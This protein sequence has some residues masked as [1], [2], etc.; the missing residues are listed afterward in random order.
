MRTVHIGKLVEGEFR[1]LQKE[2]PEYTVKWLAE[3]MC[4]ERRNI[5]NIFERSD[6]DTDLLTRLSMVLRHNFY[7]DLYDILVAELAA[8]KQQSQ[9]LNFMTTAHQGYA[10]HGLWYAEVIPG[11]FDESGE[12]Q[13][14]LRKFDQRELAK[15]FT[16]IDLMFFQADG[17]F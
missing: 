10:Q 16:E 12:P 3:K 7:K 4:C 14:A 8:E 11:K 15:K 13:L 1:E 17:H 9:L 2:H 6:L 5:Y